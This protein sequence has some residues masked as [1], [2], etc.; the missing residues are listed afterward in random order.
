[1]N[2]FKISLITKV[3]AI[4]VFFASAGLVVFGFLGYYLN[5]SIV[6]ENMGKTAASI[7]NT[8]AL[9]ID[10]NEFDY[11]ITKREKNYY[12]RAL[13]N[14]V[15]QA[16]KGNDIK[17]LYIVD[18]KYDDDVTFI[19][20][21][22]SEEGR[23]DL[24]EMSMGDKRPA[25]DFSTKLFETIDSGKVISTG[26]YSI[27]HR[28]SLVSGF[29]PIL[30]KNGKAI[31]VVGVDL[32]LD[33][34][35][36][37]S[38]S[39]GIY[40]VII[41]AVTSI[42]LAIAISIYMK[43]SVKKPITKLSN[44]AKRLANGDI[45]FEIFA[46]K[47]DEIGELI[48]SFRHMI[49]M[50]GEQ[51]K[52]LE[53]MAEG[54][55]SGEITPRSGE[56]SMGAAIVKITNSLN[57]SLREIDECAQSIAHG[58]RQIMEDSRRLSGGTMTQTSAIEG[59]SEQIS[60]LTGDTKENAVKAGMAS[61]LSNSIKENAQTGSSR[62]SE[63]LT[64]VNEI[65]D[66]AQSIGKMVRVIDNIAFRTNILALNASVEAA[67][68][69]QNSGGF[70]VVANEVRLLATQS[71]DVSKE[72]TALVTESVKKTRYGSELADAAVDA[73]SEIAYGIIQSSAI[74]T[75][76]AENCDRQSMA[77]ERI[78]EGIGRVSEVTKSS[79]E[80]A[81]ESAEA[82]SEMYGQ[83]VKLQDNIAKFKLK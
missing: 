46:L 26:I 52:I 69:G 11:V 20:E 55:L 74:V 9:N 83:A 76:I 30:D 44:A 81:A 23:E 67:R 34:V 28:G 75:E 25:V 22:F 5:K 7:A 15:D 12:W 73:F 32:D 43:K 29:A 78:N 56:D 45:D 16:L 48:T 24:P 47:N 13:K 82:S 21:G 18:A 31:A 14:I 36:A 1:M 38:G 64:A 70:S 42:A 39:F 68:A 65:N 50:T 6:A 41:G 2:K 53:R 8:I 80:S 62:M 3:T 10:I 61:E 4:V 17:F 35:L 77:I 72:M 40:T 60:R 63:M 19:C 33:A 79:G 49:K 59:L 51:V 37:Q 66:S 27:A 54:D 71:I 57:N 58:S